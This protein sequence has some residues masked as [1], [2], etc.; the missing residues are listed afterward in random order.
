[1]KNKTR[2]TLS[3]SWRLDKLSAALREV[4]DETIDWFRWVRAWAR[5][6]R[7]RFADKSALRTHADVEADTL[8][9]IAVVEEAARAHGNDIEVVKLGAQPWRCERCGRDKD[10]FVRPKHVRSTDDL[11]CASCWLDQS[12]KE[13]SRGEINECDQMP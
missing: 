5:I 6:W 8:K 4:F 7:V 12:R 13:P 10:V 1:M 11:M 9:M 2:R 3:K